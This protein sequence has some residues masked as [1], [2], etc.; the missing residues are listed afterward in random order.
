MSVTAVHANVAPP[1]RRGRATPAL[2]ARIVKL[3]RDE[4]L[5]PHAI[6]T[7]LNAQGVP[8]V[9]GGV[10]WQASTVAS[11]LDAAGYGPPSGVD[12]LLAKMIVAMRDV[13]GGT[14]TAIA[15]ALNKAGVPSPRSGRWYPATLSRL[16]PRLRRELAAA[17]Q[18]P[19]GQA[20]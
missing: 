5:G 18:A 17:A 9:R 6:A 15:D 10:S 1:P 13:D 20:T 4:G 3:H 16:L 12:L 8:T 14:L 11:I 19:G 2:I 7:R